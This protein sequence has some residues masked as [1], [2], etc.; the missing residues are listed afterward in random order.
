MRKMDRPGYQ[1]M[2]PTLRLN[3]KLRNYMNH[4]CLSVLDNKEFFRQY[5][6][7]AVDGDV[8]HEVAQGYGLSIDHGTHYPHCTYRN[9]LVA[10]ALDDLGMPAKLVGR[11]IL[12][13]RTF[14]IRVGNLDGNSSGDFPL[15]SHETTWEEIYE[16]AGFPQEERKPEYTTVTKRKRRVATPSFETLRMAALQ[17]DATESVVTF[18]EYLGWENRLAKSFAELN[19]RAYRYINLVEE[20]TGVP[21]IGISTG[22]M[23]DQMIWR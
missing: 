21:V 3:P 15:D 1:L 14:P 16:A 2:E 12:V 20:T 10:S 22:P 6:K 23:H 13:V 8:L 17:N 4:G 7:Q 19:D 11:V 9:C 5:Y 18:I